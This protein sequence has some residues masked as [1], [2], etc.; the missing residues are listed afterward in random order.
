MKKYK[1]ILFQSAL[2]PFLLCCDKNQ[3]PKVYENKTPIVEGAQVISMRPE[4][5]VV[6]PG[7]LYSWNKVSIYPKVKGYVKEVKADRGTEVKK[8]QVLAILDAPELLTELDKAQGQLH[9]AEAALHQAKAR[10]YASKSTYTKLVQASQTPGAVA[11]HEL[12][13]AKANMLADSSA[14]VTAE[15]NLRAARSHYHTQSEMAKYLTVTAPFNGTII[16][17]NISPGTLIGAGDANGKPMFI[18]EDNSTLRLTVAIPEKYSN[19]LSDSIDI[20]FSVNAAPDQE[21]KAKFGRSSKSIF[22][23]NRVMLTEFDSDNSEGKL[24][25][26]MYAEVKLP[27]VRSSETLFVPQTA[28]VSS[29]ERTFVI[30]SVNNK[31]EWIDVKKGVSL[32]SLTE[33]FGVLQPGELIVKEASEEIREGQLLQVKK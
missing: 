15:G 5:P 11:L 10:L 29:S 22:E 30:R 33:V 9:A 23:K 8:G 1:I 20:V 14:E 32:D 17:R 2:I 7:E 26:G 12:D 4:K 24:K 25:A 27:I 6:L 21:F 3:E 28:V 16:E 31:A 13:V 19:A 18:L